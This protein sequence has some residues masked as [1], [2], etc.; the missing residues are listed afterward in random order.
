MEYRGLGGWNKVLVGHW[1]GSGSLRSHLVRGWGFRFRL[2]GR[3]GPG[4]RIDSLFDMPSLM[5]SACVQSLR[6]GAKIISLGACSSGPPKPHRSPL[7]PRKPKPSNSKLV[8]PKP[9]TL[10]FVG[11]RGSGVGRVWAQGFRVSGFGG[12]GSRV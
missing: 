10:G 6:L 9:D 3:L 7:K 2:S 5:S 1:V 12:R 11:A 4:L 8:S